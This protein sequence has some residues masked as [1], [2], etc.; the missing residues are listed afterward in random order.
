VQTCNVTARNGCPNCKRIQNLIPV[1]ARNC[2]VDECP[3][4]RCREIKEHLRRQNAMC[5]IR[6]TRDQM[7]DSVARMDPGV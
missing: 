2:R 5:G 7:R 4:Q 6:L 1:H 3:V